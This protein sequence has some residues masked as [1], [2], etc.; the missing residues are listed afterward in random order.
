MPQLLGAFVVTD[1]SGS[2]REARRRS[3]LSGAKTGAGR[4][5]GPKAIPAK[6]ESRCWLGGSTAMV[7]PPSQLLVSRVCERRV[8]RGAVLDGLQ[9][10]L[11]VVDQGGVMMR[12]R[13]ERCGDQ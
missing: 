12:V 2:T 9:A 13:A 6:V 3:R 1:R 10:P 5:R 8:D 4:M 11:I 7:D